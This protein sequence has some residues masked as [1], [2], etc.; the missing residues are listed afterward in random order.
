[1]MW[2]NLCLP[3]V[4]W[5]IFPA[6]WLPSSNWPVTHCFLCLASSRPQSSG[7]A[8]SLN[9]A[10][11]PVSQR[12][13]KHVVSQIANPF[14]TSRRRFPRRREGIESST[15]ADRR[16]TPQDKTT[17]THLSFRFFNSQHFLSS[18]SVYWRSVNEGIKQ[19]WFHF[20]ITDIA[21]SLL[22]N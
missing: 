2:G 13:D 22:S 5:I 10:H 19:S 9:Y 1:M 4:F 14:A 11:A 7:A 16:S 21:I 18:A 6:T 8:L 20:T 15:R 12:V 3:L 17:H